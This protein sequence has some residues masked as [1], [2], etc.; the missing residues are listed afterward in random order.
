MENRYWLK[1]VFLWSVAIFFS[2]WQQSAANDKKNAAGIASG[3]MV[4]YGEMREVMVWV[5]T[6]VKASVSLRYREKGNNGNWKET[7]EAET[8]KETAYTAKLIATPLEPGKKYDYRIVLNGKERMFPFR[9]EFQTPPLW[10]WR[11]DPPAFSVAA[12]SCLYVNE[13]QYDRPGKPYGGDYQI[14]TAIAEKKPDIMIWLGDNVYLREADWYSRTGILHRY[15]HTRSLPELQPLMASAQN[16]AIWDDHDYGPND[17]DRGYW[18]KEVSLEAFRLFW[19]NPSFGIN[20]KPSITTAFEWGDAQFFLLDN[21]WDRTPNDRKTGNRQM[22][23]KEQLDWLIDN[24]AS[25]KATFKVVVAGGQMLNPST[26]Y[27]TFSRFPE[28][29]REF[30]EA[31][32]KENINGVILLTGD[33]HSGELAVLKREGTYPLYEITTSP[34]TSTPF[35]RPD[36]LHQIVEPGTVVNDRNFAVMEFSGKKND[37]ALTL[38]MFDKSGSERWSKTIH[39][40][41]LQSKKK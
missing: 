13:A 1:I 28:E 35:A 32:E 39:A 12:G 21:R 25:S 31:L 36:S 9:T 37:R 29:R 2:V 33:I 18:R 15:T 34:L 38:R 17:S 26:Q 4:C 30:L 40:N 24:L 10:Q 6:T 7:P 16:Y 14:L 20:G 23:G 22:F 3:P 8:N 19:G 11:T 41:E 27:E 5:Q